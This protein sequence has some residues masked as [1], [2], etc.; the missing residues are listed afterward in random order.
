[1]KL[2]GGILIVLGFTLLV[3]GGLPYKE[4][5]NV[6]EIGGLKMQVTE[7]K[8]LS[9]PPVVSGLLIAGG[10]ALMFVRRKSGV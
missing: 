1:M 2:A 6:A 5:T 4:K 3:V 10:T 7:E 9:V 8:K